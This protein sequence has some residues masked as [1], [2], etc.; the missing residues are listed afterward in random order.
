VRSTSCVE[1]SFCKELLHMCLDLVSVP[2]FATT[3]SPCYFLCFQTGLIVA[4]IYWTGW[5]GML[6]C[7][8]TSW[9]SRSL[10]LYYVLVF[11]LL[12]FLRRSFTVAIRRWWS[13][14][15]STSLKSFHDLRNCLLMQMWSIWFSVI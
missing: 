8:L 1:S 12:N 13:D 4:G 14:G 3:G 5:D 7:F 11:V 2:W 10:A 9:V 6:K 15:V